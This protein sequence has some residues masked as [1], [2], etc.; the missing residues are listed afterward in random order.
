MDFLNTWEGWQLLLSSNIEQSPSLLEPCKLSPV[1]RWRGSDQ[2][3]AAEKIIVNP[4][5]LLFLPHP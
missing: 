3:S 2:V 4:T 1:N 5:F